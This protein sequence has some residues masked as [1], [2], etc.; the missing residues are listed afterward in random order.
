MS[1][2]DA[3]KHNERNLRPNERIVYF[4]GFRPTIGDMM[5]LCILNVFFWL[6]EIAIYVRD[7][8]KDA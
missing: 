8:N 4:D 3:K 2:F 6:R 5:I 7:Y 1:D